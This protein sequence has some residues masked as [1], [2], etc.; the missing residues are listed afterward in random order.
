[1]KSSAK[2]I[3]LKSVD[4]IFQTEENRADAQRERVQEIPQEQSLWELRSALRLLLWLSFQW[5][6]QNWFL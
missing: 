6:L 3:V 4:D 2:N 5:I 1:M